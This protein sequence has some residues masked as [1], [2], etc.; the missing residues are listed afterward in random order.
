MLNLMT[1]LKHILLSTITKLQGLLSFLC[2]ETTQTLLNVKMNHV[3]ARRG[4]GF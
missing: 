3:D 4:D 1:Q 2:T